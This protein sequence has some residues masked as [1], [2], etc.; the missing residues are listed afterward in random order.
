[1][2]RL[3]S[4][5]TPRNDEEKLS[6]MNHIDPLLNSMDPENM[7]SVIKIFLRYN[8]DSPLFEQVVVRS[9]GCLI[10][11]LSENG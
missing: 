8:L 10:N 5:F 6:I 3:L 1:M 4:K 7:V 11:S 9:T 2:L